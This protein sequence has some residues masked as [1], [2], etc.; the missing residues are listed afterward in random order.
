MGVAQSV[1]LWPFW[2]QPR[3]AVTGA[4]DDSSS[5]TAAASDD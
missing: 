1:T 3:G 2:D 5:D 4:V